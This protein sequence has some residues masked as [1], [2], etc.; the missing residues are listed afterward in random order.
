[1][2]RRVDSSKKY[3][4][5]YDASRK[6]TASKF[7]KCNF[8]IQFLFVKYR[9]KKRCANCKNAN[10]LYQDKGKNIT[11]VVCAN[12]CLNIICFVK[13]KPKANQTATADCGAHITE[14]AKNCP[15]ELKT[16]EYPVIT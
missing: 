6:K 3:L 7:K 2:F 13:Q 11:I 14:Q 12:V 1:M 16:P 15:A 5:P 8:I 9:N 10:T 4:V